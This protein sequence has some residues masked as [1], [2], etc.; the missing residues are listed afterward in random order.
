MAQYSKRNVHNSP[1]YATW[2]AGLLALLATANGQCFI[3]R[4]TSGSLNLRPIRHLA[5]K[6]VFSGLEWNTFFALSLILE[7]SKGQESW[8]KE[9]TQAFF[10]VESY[11]QWGYTVLCCNHETLYKERGQTKSSYRA[12][13]AGG[14]AGVCEGKWY[15]RPCEDKR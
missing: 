2:M 10:V 13:S 5:S 14:G 9:N 7:N 11:P 6:T 3:S 1:L 4:W 15:M 12:K 8:T